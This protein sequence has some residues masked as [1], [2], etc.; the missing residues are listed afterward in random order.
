MNTQITMI[1]PKA[2]AL[3]LASDLLTAFLNVTDSREYVTV[4]SFGQ[5]AGAWTVNG[6]HLPGDM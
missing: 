2:D 6:P 1:I 3:K 4:H 5:H